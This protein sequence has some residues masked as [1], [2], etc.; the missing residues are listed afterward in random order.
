MNNGCYILLHRDGVISWNYTCHLCAKS[1]ALD[2]LNFCCHSE[3]VLKVEVK[4]VSEVINQGIML[5]A[6][7]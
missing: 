1:G 3:W 6:P 2:S 7:E 5:T 4:E